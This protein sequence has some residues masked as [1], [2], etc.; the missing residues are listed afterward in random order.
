MINWWKA[1]RCKYW[2]FPN[3]PGFW[4]APEVAL[5]FC[6][7]GYQ[8]FQ[9]LIS[10]RTFLVPI[11]TNVSDIEGKCLTICD[12]VHSSALSGN[13][14]VILS[15]IVNI[16]I[17]VTNFAK[18][19]FLFLAGTLFPFHSV[20]MIMFVSHSGFLERRIVSEASKIAFY[21]C[22][23]FMCKSCPK[24]AWIWQQVWVNFVTFVAGILENSSEICLWSWLWLPWGFHKCSWH[25]IFNSLFTRRVLLTC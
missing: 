18:I 5:T 7:S 6:L 20:L 4:L 12:W 1:A 2:H 19:I 13:V 3:L 17:N 9:K 22:K 10:I 24:A 14:C 21:S 8:Q 16:W 23:W 25:C 11:I 15:S